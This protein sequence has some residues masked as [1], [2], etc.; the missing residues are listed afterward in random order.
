MK[1]YLT[2]IFPAVISVCSH[3]AVAGADEVSHPGA[4]KINADT[5]TY[6]KSDDTYRALGNVHPEWTA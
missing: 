2:T 6:E 3:D 1:N 4:L 5:L